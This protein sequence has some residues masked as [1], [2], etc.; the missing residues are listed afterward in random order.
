[1]SISISNNKKIR[2]FIDLFVDF[3]NSKFLFGR[4][5]NFDHPL[6]K[7]P[8]RSY[9][10]PQ[11]FVGRICSTVFTYIGNIQTNK[12][13]KY[14]YTRN[15]GRFAPFFLGFQSASRPSCISFVNMGVS[16]LKRRIKNFADFQKIF[17]WIFK[18][19]KN[20]ILME[21]NF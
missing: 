19:F 18:I 20:R 6:T 1:M 9:E 4:F 15:S 12:Q 21:A 14:I 13:V 8:G 7:F 2:G 5:F 17:S 10:V 16:L 11:F 3:E